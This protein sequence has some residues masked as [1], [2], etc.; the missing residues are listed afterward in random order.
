MKKCNGDCFNC[1]YPD[2]I[3]DVSGGLSNAEKAT[4]EYQ[5]KRKLEL[6]KYWMLYQEK[7]KERIKETKKAYYEKNKERLKEYSKKYYFDHKEAYQKYHKQ[8]Y[9]KFLK[10]E[11]KTK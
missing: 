7:N 10:K 3:L 4:E 5:E 6:K 8:Y 1:I 9:L 2:C 11:C